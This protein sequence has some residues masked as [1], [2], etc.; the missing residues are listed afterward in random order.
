MTIDLTEDPRAMRVAI[1]R[2]GRGRRWASE[3]GP[4]TL[5][6]I[7]TET[8]IHQAR[9]VSEANGDTGEDA[10]TRIAYAALVSLERYGSRLM[11]HAS[12][13]PSPPFML[14]LQPTP[15]PSAGPTTY[16]QRFEAALS[17]LC[18][19]RT[20]PAAAVDAWLANRPD[21]PG[22][23][24]QLLDWAVSNSTFYWALGIGVLDAAADLAQNRE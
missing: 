13:N 15:G 12:L 14:A 11:D 24:Y 1:N 22:G 6:S 19:Y 9:C 4:E 16:R 8:V 7:H 18:N 20:P 2:A 5:G 17:V 23:F 21:L 3:S 10:M